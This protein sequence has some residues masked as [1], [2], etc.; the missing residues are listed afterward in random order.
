MHAFRLI[1]AQ[2]HLINL[3]TRLSCKYSL[4]PN[5]HPQ[6]H[7]TPQ[8]YI[9]FTNH[10]NSWTSFNS[11]PKSDTKVTAIY[12]P[13]TGSLITQRVSNV[14][15]NDDE[16]KQEV[17][18]VSGDGDGNDRTFGVGKKGNLRSGPTSWKNFGAV[19]GGGKKK[20]K[21]KTSWVCES[22]GYSDGQWW[23][24]CRSCDGVGTM[25]RFSEGDG[26]EGRISSGFGV[27]EKV[28]GTW[29]PQQAGDIGPVRLT[30]VNRGVDQKEWRIPL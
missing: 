1:H 18:I 6:S 3:S 2:K 24:S 8:R 12:D 15:D 14:Y 5:F 25:K 11:E 23:G 4:N 13:I 9:H 17:P 10:L 7:T 22:C 16:N 20:G 26:G 27:S 30:D 29:L 28:M 21:V 19:S